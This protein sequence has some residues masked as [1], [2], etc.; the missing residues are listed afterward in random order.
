MFTLA[1]NFSGRVSAIHFSLFPEICQNLDSNPLFVCLLSTHLTSAPQK[2]TNVP[3]W[4]R[5]GGAAGGFP[6]MGGRGGGFRGGRGGRG[7][8]HP[9][10]MMPMG[11]GMGGM[12]VPMM[13]PGMMP[14]YASDFN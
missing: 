5:G 11:M 10:M 7:G 9:G 4:Q 3:A 2:R 8:F 13:M 14:G 6:M 12:M 1:R